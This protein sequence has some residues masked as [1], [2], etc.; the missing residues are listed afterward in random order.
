MVFKAK[1]S[2]ET[3]KNVKETKRIKESKNQ[4]INVKETKRM[5]TS[6]VHTI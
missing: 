6:G 3:R 1:M 4:R 2:K 5:S